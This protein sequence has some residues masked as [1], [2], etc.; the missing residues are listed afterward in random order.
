MQVAQ[1]LR[2]IALDCELAV[3]YLADALTREDGSI[4]NPRLD[5]LLDR[6]VEVTRGHATAALETLVADPDDGATRR[7]AR[8]MILGAVAVDGAFGR[9]LELLLAQIRPFGEDAHP[10]SIRAHFGIAGERVG[11]RLRADHIFDTYVE[12]LL[13]APLVIKLSAILGPILLLGGLALAL[14]APP[15]SEGLYGWPG[16]YVGLGLCGFAN[17]A[18]GNPKP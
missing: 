11:P 12:S 10:V 9:E 3:E 1:P 7:T 5:V 13:A 4:G 17:W 16:I 14:L 6:L 18:L 2:P 8:A 15:E